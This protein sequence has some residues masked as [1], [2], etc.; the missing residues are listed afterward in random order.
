MSRRANAERRLVVAAALALTC[1]AGACAPRTST[2]LLPDGQGQPMDD[3][4][5]AAQVN[6]MAA[7]CRPV[8]ALT[9]DLRLAGR[10]DGDK[11]RGTVQVGVDADGVRMEGVPPFGAPIFILAGRTTAATLLFVRDG[12]FVRDEP[13]SSLTDAIVGV[14]LTPADLLVLLGGCGLS[15]EAV[16]G[17]RTFGGGW[18]RLDFAGG[19]RG[20]MHTTGAS[21]AAVRVAETPEWR[22]D[23]DVRRPGQPVRGVLRRKGGTRTALSFEVASPDVL[24]EL[25]AGAL[26]VRIPTEARPIPLEELRRRRAL[27]DS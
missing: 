16:T 21:P 13:V 5:V 24:A 14:A 19:L 10:V 3:A 8:R 17:A 27:G 20:W 12:V 22:V 2:V 18:V 26:D 7:P 23:Y 6:L 1:V 4:A 25:P 15:S 11:V 9:A